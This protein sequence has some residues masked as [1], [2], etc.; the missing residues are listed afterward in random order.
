MTMTSWASPLRAR[1][2]TLRFGLPGI[3][4]EQQEEADI[5]STLWIKTL[6]LIHLARGSR[7][8]FLFMV[9]QPRRN[10][11]RM[12]MHSMEVMDIQAF[13]AGRRL[14]GSW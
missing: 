11:E 5:D 10:G 6:W 13:C 9:E 2:G 14:T 8:D 4:P 12:T 3:S 7:S 1:E